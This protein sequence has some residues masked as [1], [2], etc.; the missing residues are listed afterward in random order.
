MLVRCTKAFRDLQARTWRNVGDTWEATPTRLAEIN[1]T[2]YGVMAEEITA[3]GPETAPAARSA[4][5]AGETRDVSEAPARAAVT[6]TVAELEAMTNRE[7][8]NLCVKNDVE[9]SG[10]PRKAELVESLKA[11]YGLE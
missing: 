4:S 7:L 8:V 1:R 6:P 11:F 5:K 2:R 9:T 10:R 3:G